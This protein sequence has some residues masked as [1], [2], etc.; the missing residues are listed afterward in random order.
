MQHLMNFNTVILS[1]AENYKPTT[2]CTYLYEAA[3]K[4]NTFYHDCSVGNA[5]TE[6]LR[7]ARLALSAA[8]GEILKEGLS[9]LGIPV[10][11]RM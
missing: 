4:F 8:T 7:Q 2:L 3:K 11:E 10:P 9:L 1:S 5:E 6:A